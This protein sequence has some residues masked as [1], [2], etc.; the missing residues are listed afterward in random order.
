MSAAVGRR[1]V[2]ARRA[3]LVAER[4]L[5]SRLALHQGGACLPS[6]DCAS[7]LF[8]LAAEI[9]R[10][11]LPVPAGVDLQTA[12]ARGARAAPANGSAHAGQPVPRDSGAVLP[13]DGTPRRAADHGAVDRRGAR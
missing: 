13:R 2:G 7:V 8:V 4:W 3:A 12:T 10:L 9:Q 1:P 6:S 11:P 5:D